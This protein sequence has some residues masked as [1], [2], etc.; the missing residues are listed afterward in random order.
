MFSIMLWTGVIIGG[1]AVYCALG[2]QA[3]PK[4]KDNNDSISNDKSNEQETYEYFSNLSLE[5]QKEY[6]NDNYTLQDYV[7][8][9][10]LGYVEDKILNAR[11]AAEIS[12][13]TKKC[14]NNRFKR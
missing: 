6:F 10:T 5:Q 9:P 4:S 14:F 2:G 11:H 12:R 1:S 3:A 7:D 13:K 8:S